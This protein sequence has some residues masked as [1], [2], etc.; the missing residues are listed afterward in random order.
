MYPNNSVVW[1]FTHRRFEMRNVKE[2]FYKVQ[3]NFKLSLDGHFTTLFVIN[4]IQL[5]KWKTIMLNNNLH[6]HNGN[7][8]V[9]NRLR[10]FN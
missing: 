4:K 2:K 6:L 9:F 5:K 8:A 3:L 1:F 7:F 10:I